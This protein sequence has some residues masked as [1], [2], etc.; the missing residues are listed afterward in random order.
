LTPGGPASTGG[1]LTGIC[2][3]AAANVAAENE[4]EGADGAVDAT[5]GGGGG[6]TRAGLGAG[7]VPSAG[8]GVGLVPRAGLGAGL[9]PSAGLG[10]ALVLGVGFGTGEASLTGGRGGLIFNVIDLRGSSAGAGVVDALAFFF[11][12]PFATG[13]SLGLGNTPVEILVFQA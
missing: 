8:L 3:I 13:S 2:C 9:V 4:G 11:P 1:V 7:L 6:G 12:F 5:G 10:A